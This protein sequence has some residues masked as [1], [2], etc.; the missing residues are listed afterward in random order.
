MQISI[1]QIGLIIHY[2]IAVGITLQRFY[3]MCSAIEV[4]F[5]SVRNSFAQVHVRRFSRNYL[6]HRLLAK[7]GMR[8]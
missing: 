3:S 2:I 6:H 8:S 7:F 1:L 4:P 5:E